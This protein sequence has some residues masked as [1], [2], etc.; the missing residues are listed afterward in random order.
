ME[1]RRALDHLPT[2][3]SILRHSNGKE[4]VLKETGD[5]PTPEHGQWYFMRFE[6]QGKELRAFVAQLRE[7]DGQLIK[8]TK[9]EAV[10]NGVDSGPHLERGRAG[11]SR[12]VAGN[13]DARLMFKK[14]RVEKL[15]ASSK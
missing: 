10:D 12:G 6:V 7:K 2:H 14:V 15:P 11:L 9:I 5:V 8:K 4:T 3:L 1:Y 13:T